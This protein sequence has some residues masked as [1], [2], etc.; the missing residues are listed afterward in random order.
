MTIM[1]CAFQGDPKILRLYGHARSI[2]PRDNDWT[3]RLS[4]FT[5]TTGVRQLIE[6]DIELVHTSCGFGVPLYNF[7]GQRDT[8]TNWIEKKGEDGITQYWEDRNSQSLNGKTNG[9]I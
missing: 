7:N 2:H 5:E 3:E 6:M 4:H 1:F 8:L 9:D